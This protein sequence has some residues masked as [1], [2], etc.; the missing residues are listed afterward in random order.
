MVYEFGIAGRKEEEF[1]E[2]KRGNLRGNMRNLV[3]LICQI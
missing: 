2:M 1:G 3:M